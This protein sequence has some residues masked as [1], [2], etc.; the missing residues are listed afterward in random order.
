MLAEMV[1]CPHCKRYIN[2]EVEVLRNDDGN[3][4]CLYCGEDIHSEKLYK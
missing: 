4:V 3:V 1:R 2:L